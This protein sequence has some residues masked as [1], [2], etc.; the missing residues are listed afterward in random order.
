MNELFS[1]NGVALLF[2]WHANNSKEPNEL[3]CFVDCP[4]EFRGKDKTFNS[5]NKCDVFSHEKSNFATITS[6]TIER[7]I[8]KRVKWQFIIE[9]PIDKSPN[10]THGKLVAIYRNDCVFVQTNLNKWHDLFKT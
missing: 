1:L 8:F 2:E 10:D 4:V 6:T 7:V 5:I 9:L 3:I